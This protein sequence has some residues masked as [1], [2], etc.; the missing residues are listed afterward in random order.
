MFDFLKKKPA[1]EATPA[2]PATPVVEPLPATAPDLPA[3]APVPAGP[4]E[5][6]PQRSWAARLRD[7]LSKTRAKLNAAVGPT[8]GADV[9][10]VMSDLFSRRKIDDEIGRAHV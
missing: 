9:G 7:G 10:D 4:G 8:L 1:T 3:A 2:V 5:P 6:A